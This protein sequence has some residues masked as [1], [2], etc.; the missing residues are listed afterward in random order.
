MSRAAEATDVT[1]AGQAD[2]PAGLEIADL[3]RTF[4]SVVAVDRLS[5]AVPRGSMVALL[6]PSGCGKSTTLQMI[7]GLLDPTSGRI[8]VDGTDVTRAPSHRRGLGFVFQDYALYPHK[9]VREN[10]GFPLRMAGVPRAEIDLRVT[11]ELDRVRLTDKGRSRPQELS[12]GQQQRVAL[13]RAL[14]KR[15]ALLLF[16]EP[17]SNLDASLRGDMRE[18]I[19]DVHLEIGATSVFVTHD[20]DEALNIADYVAVMS[21]GRLMQLARP[22]E[23]YDAPA[24]VFVAR[25]IGRPAMRLH[26]AVVRAGAVHL[27]GREICPA[28]AGLAD[29]TELLAGTRPE[30]VEVVDG[31]EGGAFEGTVRR[32]EHAGA[33]DFV[34]VVVTDDVTLTVRTRPGV[35]AGDARAVRLRTASS[36]WHLFDAESQERV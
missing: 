22:R 10:V 15:P 1:E 32:I 3:S 36:A 23:I 13:A 30:D 20:Q 34:E 2:A 17:L 6:G 27:A 29:E 35:V 16:D 31:A 19:R 24:N 11:E 18:L 5:L 33:D 21:A 4:G 9:T 12:G 28:P 14:V 26:P 25:F 7:A 8:V